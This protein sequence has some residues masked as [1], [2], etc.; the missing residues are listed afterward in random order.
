MIKVSIVTPCYNDGKYLPEAVESVR[1]LV[2]SG[3]CEHIVVDDGS[4]DQKTK[5]LYKTLDPNLVKIIFSERVG[6]GAARNIGIKAASA[7]YYLNLDADNKIGPEYPK[8]AA[9]ILDENPDT[10][11][12]FSDYEY[13]GDDSRKVKTGKFNPYKLLYNNYIDSCSVIRK[14]VWKDTGGYDEKEMFWEDWNF[15]IGA[16]DTQWK[17]HHLDET[18]FYYRIREGESLRSKFHYR[19]DEVKKYI[20]CR[21]GHVYQKYFGELWEKVRYIDDI[22]YIKSLEDEIV[23]LHEIISEAEKSISWKITKPLRK[24]NSILRHPKS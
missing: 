20:A 12:V 22:E 1:P 3:F 6:L 18:M 13:F 19:E 14:Q 15:W 5:A 4:T 16:L 8:K 7:D 11:V 10:G 9:S 2:E 21:Y 23:N 17:F 24:L